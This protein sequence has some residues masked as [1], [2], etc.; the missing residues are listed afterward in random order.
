MKLPLSN[1]NVK[2]SS[3]TQEEMAKGKDVSKTILAGSTKN[4][5]STKRKITDVEENSRL[6]FKK[7]KVQDNNHQDPSIPSKHM[8]NIEHKKLSNK[9]EQEK[10]VEEKHVEMVG[11]V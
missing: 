9:C 8:R 7:A 2:E 10:N 4:L 3:N 11:D 1:S 6:S 5:S